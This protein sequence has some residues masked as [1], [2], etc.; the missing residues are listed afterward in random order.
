LFLNQRLSTFESDWRSRAMGNC[1]SCPESGASHEQTEL[2]ATESHKNRPGNDYRLSLD[3][4]N[5]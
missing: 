3:A 2:R 5:Y 1:V 4:F